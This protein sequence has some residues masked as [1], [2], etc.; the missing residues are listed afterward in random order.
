L[1]DEDRINN[2]TGTDGER[3]RWLFAGR[4]HPDHD[5]RSGYAQVWREKTRKISTF[6]KSDAST[7]QDVG[8]DV[9]RGINGYE[10]S[11][12]LRNANRRRTS[13]RTRSV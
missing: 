9:A 12:F 10:D 4:T 6:K 3:C 1:F 5:S 8:A 7:F 11:K 2:A 13:L